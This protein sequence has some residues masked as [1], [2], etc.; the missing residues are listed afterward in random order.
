MISREVFA[1]YAR[2]FIFG[3]EDSLV[4]TVGLLSGIA[5]G[6]IGREE[7]VLAGIV[8]IF[9]E[10]FS[11]GAGSFLAERSVE[12]YME[13]DGSKIPQQSVGVSFTMFGSYFLSGFIPLSP[14]IFLEKTMALPVSIIFSLV[15]LL[16][17]GIV[18]ARVLRTS[19]WRTARRVLIIGGL[20]I[21]VGLALGNLFSIGA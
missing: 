2:N 13:E 7:V 14:Y 20:A 19:V 11:M 16:V 17:L 18:S 12:E 8:L 21:G 10:A 9:V 6:G 15:A 5:V 3:V 1:T 4:S